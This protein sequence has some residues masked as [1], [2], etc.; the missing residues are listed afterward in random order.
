[1]NSRTVFL[2]RPVLVAAALVLQ[3][4]LLAVTV[5]P[6]LSAR[7]TGTEYRLA[8]GPVDPIDPLRGAYAQLT[9]P[10][11]PTPHGQRPGR[12]YVPLVRDGHLW[13]GS[14]IVWQR[15]A[16]GPYIA[17]ES[18]G[19]GWLSCGIDSLF[20]PQD[21]AARV[22]DELVGDR[23]AAIV[24]IDSNGNAAVVGLAPR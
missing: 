21:K 5:A 18:A 8:V 10:G 11:L 13:K 4:V 9:Y 22:Q 19:N 6:R 16:S 17:C 24:K 14:G 3:A 15:P 2:S 12:V 7:M 23:A 1:M 20:L